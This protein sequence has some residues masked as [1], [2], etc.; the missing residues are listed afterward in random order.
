MH[1]VDYH[2]V[3]I[4]E[5]TKMSLFFPR[6]TR[7]VEMLTALSLFISGILGFAGISMIP[8]ALIDVHNPVFWELIAVVFG[9][10]QFIMATAFYRATHVRAIIAWFVGTFFVWLSVAALAHQ[11]R[12]SEITTL[13]VG[14]T[15]LYAFIVNA[16]LVRKQWN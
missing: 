14:T 10:M 9:I 8:V 7:L 2:T 13:I 6:D 5:K 15:N 1:D 11:V 4:T 12:P 16:L 3:F